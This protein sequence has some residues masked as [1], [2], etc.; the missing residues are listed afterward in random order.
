M[1]ANTP[2][3]PHAEGDRFTNTETGITYEF[4]SG[5]WRAVSS[6][7]ADAV[8][9]AISELDLEKVLTAGNV[10]D[11]D[12][13]LTDGID[14]LIDISPTE[15]RIVIASDADTKTPKITLAHFGDIDEG[16]RKAEI[17][18]DENGTR[19][20]FEMS[21]DV[22]DVHFRFGDD[23]KF[24]LNHE[25]D[26]EFIG[27]VKVEPGT[28]QN[29]VVTYQQLNELEEEIEDLRPSIERGNWEFKSDSAP[30]VGNYTLMRVPT[31]ADCTTEYVECIANAGGDSTATAACNRKYDECNTAALDEVPE[32]VSNWIATLVILNIIDSNTE[33]HTFQD[34]EAGEYLE[35]A[36]ENGSGFALYEITEVRTNQSGRTYFEVAHVRS[37]GAPAGKTKV[38]VFELASGDPADYVRKAGD[39]MTGR[40]KIERPRTDGNANSFI[41]RG[42]VGGVESTLL[43]D[44]QRETSSEL[45]D[46]IEYFGAIS[47][48][49]CIANKKYVDN[50]VT[51]VA[52]PAFHK[53]AFREGANKEDLKPGEFTGPKNPSYGKGKHYSYYFHPQ[54]VTGAMEF[55]KDYDMYFPMNALWGAFH[56]LNEGKW[57]IKQYVPV[58]NIHMFKDDNY[59]EIYTHTDYPSGSAII[60]SFDKDVEYYFSVGGII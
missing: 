54:S 58:R 38:K 55:Y 53:W 31:T 9:D 4:K 60:S 35:L 15:G 20:D 14:D 26:A 3:K 27:K 28:E 1:T 34:A 5:A 30:T 51:A 49:N 24:I 57:K 47:S 22:K 19:L 7:A 2:P 29:E 56:Y 59:L 21:G 10:A 13:V 12:I 36:N 46:Y 32:Y 42:R 16:N 17:E 52:G 50:A 43:K 33:T 18:L 39:T 8:V 45:S 23:E 41:I 37:S 25:G 6:E 48:E 11:K 44:Y 40:L